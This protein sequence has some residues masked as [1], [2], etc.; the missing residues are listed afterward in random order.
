M[1]RNM[2]FVKKKNSYV[3]RHVLPTEQWRRLDLR[4]LLLLSLVLLLL[5]MVGKRGVDLVDDF[6]VNDMRGSPTLEMAMY[7][8]L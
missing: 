8:C 2:R 7:S 5:L 4:I 1:G 6:S 3:Y